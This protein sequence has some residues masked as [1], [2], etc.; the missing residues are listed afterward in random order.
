MSIYQ[1]FRTTFTDKNYKYTTTVLHSGFVIAFA[2]DD[3]R[4]IYY[5][6]LDSMQAPVD[7]PE[8]R[9]LSFPEEITTVGNALFYPT[10][11][12]IV[13]KQDNIEELP[14]E[15][16][17]G[18]IDN[19][20]QDPFLSTTAFLT[21]DQPFQIFS[22]GRY[23][24]LFRQAIA[25]D[26]KLMV[27][28]TGQRRGERGTR[29]KNRDDVY[30]ENGEAVPVANQTLLVDRFVFSLGGEQGPTL[31]PKLE[32]RYQRSKHKTLRQ[33]NK[34]TLGTED[35]AQNKFYE[36]TQELSLVGKM[37]K[38]MFSV[39]QLPTQ[40]NEQKRWQ[41]F[42]Y[43]NTTG[44]LDSFNI[45]VAKDGLFNTFGTRRYTSPDP[46]Y[47]SA[48][49]ER[50]PG[51][52]P[53]TKKPLILITE[54][55]GAAES[56]LRFLGKEDKSSVTVANT[57]ERMDI[58]KDNSFTVECWAKAEKVDG[59]HR[60][61]SQHTDDGKVTTAGIVKKKLSFYIS[62]ESGHGI[63]SSETYTDSDWHH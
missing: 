43:N 59:F 56:A 4:K 24:Y 57:D 29:D 36:P 42:C 46:E 35:M 33:S 52:C 49:F 16:Q 1:E 30:K 6:V 62:N 31:Q 40:I 20:D 27:Y 19:T 22:D 3:D 8:P 5:T 50:Q 11:M 9:L 15:L 55:G 10:P 61:F 7:L 53:F 2:M 21:A 13:K 58:F 37:H 23:I 47:Q 41:I 14:E 18:R 12:P 48:V 45:E 44:L 60:F 25:E 63:I 54:K 26:H 34:D 32:I 38:G 39:L 28:P 17:E 51:S